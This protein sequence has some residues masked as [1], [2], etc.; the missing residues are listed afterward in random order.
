MH[1]NKSKQKRVTSNP[2][3]TAR[4]LPVV[5]SYY[6]VCCH[7]CEL[8][9]VGFSNFAREHSSTHQNV[10]STHF[11]WSVQTRDLPS[12]LDKAMDGSA[13][14]KTSAFGFFF[15]FFLVSSSRPVSS[16]VQHVRWLLLFIFVFVFFFL[17]QNA[18]CEYCLYYRFVFI[19]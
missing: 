5:A 9:L 14:L 16:V 1:G 4:Q 12:S 7:H 8:P 18:D 6:L 11:P 17:S 15:F 3:Q 13:V 10:P 2:L 19:L